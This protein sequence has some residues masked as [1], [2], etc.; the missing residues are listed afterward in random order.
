M[1]HPHHQN[2]NLFV[3]N[4]DRD[5]ASSLGLSAA[6]VGR[7]L[8]RKIGGELIGKFREG[9]ERLDI[10]LRAQ[11]VFRDQASEIEDLRLRLPVGRSSAAG[12]DAT[13][14]TR[15]TWAP[16]PISVARKPR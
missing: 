2:W 14:R 13:P 5:R 1:H 6:D 7:A 15:S 10:R 3:V 12:A 16:A 11:E 8:R 4:S 9:E